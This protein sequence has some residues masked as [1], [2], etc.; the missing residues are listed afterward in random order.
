[1]S[2][3]CFPDIWKEAN[4][5]PMYKKDDSYLVSNCRPI[6]L[7]IALGKVMKKLFI[8]TCLTFFLNQQAFT[9]LHSGFVPSDSTVYQLIFIIILFVKALDGDN[10]V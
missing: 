7:L 1:M 10:D 4:I 2:M 8:N 5:S 6:S 9:C 3:S